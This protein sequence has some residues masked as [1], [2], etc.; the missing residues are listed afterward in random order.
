MT[1]S[2]PNGI[3]AGVFRPGR[4]PQGG[5][6]S[7]KGQ[8][9]RLLGAIRD[10]V[11][12]TSPVPPLST[13]ELHQHVDRLVASAEVDDRHKKYA[14]VLLNNEVWRETLAAV[15]FDRRLLLMPQ[16]L[17]DQAQCPAEVDGYGLLCAGCG[18]CVIADLQ[19]EAEKLGY[20]VLVAEGTAVVTSLVKGRTIDAVVG[21]SCLSVLEKVFPFME[22]GAVPGIA[23]PLLNDGC[24]DTSLDVDWL[25]E[26]IYLTSEDRTRR[27]DLDALRRQVDSWFA[28]EPLEA[29]LGEAG[30]QTERIAREWLARSGKRWRP[31]LAVCACEALQ[32]D[33]T[34][35]VDEAL[36][37]VAVAVECFHKA[38]LIH[39]DI[40]DDDPLRYGRQTLHAEY[41][42]PI[43]LNVGDFLLGEGYRLLAGCADRTDA[44]VRMLAAAAAGHRELCAGQGAELCWRRAPGP[45]TVEQVVDIFRRKTGPAFE[46]ALHLGAIWGAADDDVLAAL[47]A[48]SEAL[49]IAYQIRDDLKDISS[50]GSAG[51]PTPSVLLAIACEQASGPMRERLEALWRDAAGP[52][53]Q[54]A[55]A[56]LLA[57]A[58]L[59]RQAAKLLEYYKRRAILSL[60]PLGNPSLKGLLR[61]VIGRILAPLED[62]AESNE[63]KVGD[64]AGRQFGAKSSA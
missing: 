44:A 54:A 12:R 50:D 9:D 22:S 16:C 58:D 29:L 39:D 14:S 42:V 32:D 3:S 62:G 21:A 64:V 46:V 34:G 26:A 63:H 5:I 13:E 23:I 47:S 19:A 31:F 7:A 45:L 43:A 28:P 53:D 18:R 40:E 56:E 41:G 51:E 59:R 61:R 6:P 48:Y 2:G 36:R 11:R 35:P 38:S 57:G 37:R 49:G 20:A 17:R 10:Y 24:A 30:G 15:P 8:R 52:A 25:R 55:A 33:P 4:C 1:Q 27:L 60:R